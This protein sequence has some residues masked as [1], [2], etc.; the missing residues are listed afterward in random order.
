MTG[1]TGYG[2]NFIYFVRNGDDAFFEISW[3]IAGRLRIK[4]PNTKE[5]EPQ[6]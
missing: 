1:N 4:R 2:N 6:Q 3:H 5:T